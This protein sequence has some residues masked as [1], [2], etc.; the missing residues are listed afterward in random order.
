[1]TV[2]EARA[3]T[4]QFTGSRPLTVN[5]VASL[6][7]QAWANHTKHAR[8]TWWALATEAHVP[9]LDR[10]TIDATPLHK[11]RRSPQDVGACSPEVKAAIDGLVD[12]GVIPDDNPNHLLAVRFLP[13]RI[14]GH[15]GL[16][17]TITEVTA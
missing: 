3:W 16:E 15:D 7:R 2:A 5:A 11:D 14:C 6:H 13:P 12:A 8:F 17:L 10:I 1:M 4:V 9:S